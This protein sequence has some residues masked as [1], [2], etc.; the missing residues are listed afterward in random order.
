MKNVKRKPCNDDD[1]AETKRHCEKEA[2][3]RSNPIALGAS[4]KVGLLRRSSCQ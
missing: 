1:L 4:S 2:R 3:R